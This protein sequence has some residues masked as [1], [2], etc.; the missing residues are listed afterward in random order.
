MIGKTKMF[1]S[2]RV[3]PRN[4]KATRNCA[5]IHL[6]RTRSHK[7]GSSWVVTQRRYSRVTQAPLGSSPCE[8][9]EHKTDTVTEITTN[10]C[11]CDLV[12]LPPV[13]LHTLSA[14]HPEVIHGTVLKH[15]EAWCSTPNPTAV[16]LSIFKGRELVFTFKKIHIRK[17]SKSLLL[18]S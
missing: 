2:S 3:K 6:P 18:Y 12:S 15:A 11:Y 13:L 4:S 1:S 8:N 10:C 7:A 16:C 14:P 5:F 17:I 9:Y